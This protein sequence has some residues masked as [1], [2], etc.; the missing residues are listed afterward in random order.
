MLDIRIDTIDSKSLNKEI[1]QQL[2]KD[3]LKTFTQKTLLN[4]YGFKFELPGKYQPPQPDIQPPIKQQY[5]V[6]ELLIYNDKEFI[7]NCYLCLLH[8]QA[9]TK[10]VHNYLEKLRNGKL[11]KIDIISS[12]YLSKERRNLGVRVSGLLTR[13]IFSTADKI[14]V[15]GYFIRFFFGFLLFTELQ[16]Q[17]EQ[18]LDTLSLQLTQ[19]NTSLQ[20]QSQYHQDAINQILKTVDINNKTLLK[21]LEKL[22]TTDETSLQHIN[23]ALDNETC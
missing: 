6:A 11:N 3:R 12:L 21:G 9:D 16:K 4:K 17:H 23:K 8:R 13:L 19:I 7:E 14:P 18:E 10:G 15:A 5:S 1:L 2:K 22:I 20:K